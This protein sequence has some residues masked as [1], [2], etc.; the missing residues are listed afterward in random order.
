MHFYPGFT[1]KE[2]SLQM[3]HNKPKFPKPRAAQDRLFNS[4]LFQRF[5]E[6]LQITRG[7]QTPF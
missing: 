7:M 2:T 1:N 5:K 4:V 6:H 3:F